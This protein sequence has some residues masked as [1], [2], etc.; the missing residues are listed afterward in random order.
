MIRAT[1]YA[2]LIIIQALL[3]TSFCRDQVYG[4]ENI[5]LKIYSWHM[6]MDKISRYPAPAKE[7]K[8]RTHSTT[9]IPGRSHWEEALLCNASAHWP[10]PY[11]EWSVR[12]LWIRAQPMREGV[13]YLLSLAEPIPRMIPG[14]VCTFLGIYCRKRGSSHKQLF[15]SLTYWPGRWSSN[16]KLVNSIPMSRINT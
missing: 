8:A 13:T 12:T 11:S 4:N 14:N 1:N 15:I 10:S 2:P 3:S 7:S 6:N 5:W 16:I 9:I